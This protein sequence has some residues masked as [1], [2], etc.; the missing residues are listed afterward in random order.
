MN[1][2]GNL[3]CAL[4]PCKARLGILAAPLL[5]LYCYQLAL[6]IHSLFLQDILFVLSVKS[7]QVRKLA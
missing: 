4:P 5:L 7:Y 1:G 2:L 3:L 6:Q